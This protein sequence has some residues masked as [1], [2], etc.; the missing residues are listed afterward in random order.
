[1]RDPDVIEIFAVLWIMH[2]VAALFFGLP[3]W[4]LD[5]R[6]LTS[7]DGSLFVV[8]FGLWAALMLAEVSPKSLG[9]LVEA[10]FLGAAIG[11]SFLVRMF[12]GSAAPERSRSLA[13]LALACLIA[14]LLYTLTPGLPE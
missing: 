13:H 8:P 4:L 12:V 11:V 10:V 7:F 9:N 2:V 14:L 5:R 3:A 1:M 6:R